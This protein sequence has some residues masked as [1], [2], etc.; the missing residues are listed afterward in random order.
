MPETTPRI[1]R[2]RTIIKD[3]RKLSLQSCLVCAAQFYGNK[4]QTYCD[5]CAKKTRQEMAQ[6]KDLDLAQLRGRLRKMTDQELLAFSRDS[7]FMCAKRANS[8]NPADRPFLKQ[9]KEARLEYRR[10]NPK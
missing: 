9:W 5:A 2:A 6:L 1:E 7:L 3:G 8:G 4:Q 10:R